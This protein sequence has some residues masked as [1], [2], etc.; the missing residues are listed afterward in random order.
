MSEELKA[1]NGVKQKMS[2]LE[3][4]IKSLLTANKV[5]L[6]SW[7]LCIGVWHCMMVDHYTAHVVDI[8]HLLLSILLLPFSLPPAPPPPPP[9]CPPSSSFPSPSSPSLPPL[10]PPPSSPPPPPQDMHDERE[11]T[12]QAKEEVLAA[13]REAE[14]GL[15]DTR[16]QMEAQELVSLHFR[17]CCVKILHTKF[18]N[19]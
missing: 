17:V 12:Q 6:T 18:T 1:L 2:S 5:R 3:E 11:G 15:R 8:P 14:A 7:R 10:P 13:K 16:K 4:E 19:H 9:P